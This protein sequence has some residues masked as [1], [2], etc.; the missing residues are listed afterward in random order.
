MKKFNNLMTY[1]LLCI[2]VGCTF[3]VEETF[4]EG[5]NNQVTEESK[6]DTDA[7]LKTNLKIPVIG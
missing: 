3:N 1:I 5:E 4:I 2:C 7:N 6:S